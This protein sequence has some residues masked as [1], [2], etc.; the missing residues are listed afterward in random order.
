M[1]EDVST[2]FHLEAQSILKL[3]D[4][5]AANALP[6][7]DA[8]LALS[9]LSQQLHN[10][11]KAIEAVT[12]SLLEICL[13]LLTS[14]EDALVRERAARVVGGLVRVM[15]GSARLA[16]RTREGS[17]ALALAEAA[18][19]DEALGVRRGCA[20]ALRSFA[21]CGGREAPGALSIMFWI[22]ALPLLVVPAIYLTIPAG[23]LPY[24]ELFAKLMIWGHPYMAP[25][26]VAGLVGLWG[27][28]SAPPG[29]A[30]R[31]QCQ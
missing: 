31:C 24:M 8:Q 17:G 21:E 22:A 29:A 30:C 2:S 20:G 5:L 14:A 12:A 4:L 11:A 15:E 10:P 16:E 28:R 19:S 9:L 27:V 6:P 18:A 13:L 7:R 26:V 1:A 25:L 23:E 3:R